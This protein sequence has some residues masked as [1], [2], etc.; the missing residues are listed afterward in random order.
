MT[1]RTAGSCPRTASKPTTRGLWTTR[2]QLWAEAVVRYRRGDKWWVI[3]PTLQEQIAA[4]AE[5]ARHVDSWIEILDDEIGH[6]HAITMK[7]AADALKIPADH[8]TRATETRIGIALREL[9]F[10]HGKRSPA[11][12]NA[13][14]NGRNSCPTCPTPVQPM[15]GW[16]VVVSACCVILSILLSNLSNLLVQHKCVGY[17]EG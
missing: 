5:E 6:M 1:A 7:G 11:A 8:L 10:S 15:R 9:G 3:C 17:R 13:S 4:K 16:T 14:P 2:D 12:E